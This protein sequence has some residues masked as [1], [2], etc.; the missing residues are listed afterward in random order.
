LLLSSTVPP[1]TIFR[2]TFTHL[3]GIALGSAL[4]ILWQD[5]ERHRALLARFARLALV[6]GVALLTIVV[7]TGMTLRK[8]ETLAYSRSLMLAFPLAVLFYGRL[9]VASLISRSG[10][11]SRSRPFT[12]W[13]W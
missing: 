13:R 12:V 9:L 7:Y 4:A 2:I 1:A 3:D 10:S 5:R 8:G 6:L 11:P